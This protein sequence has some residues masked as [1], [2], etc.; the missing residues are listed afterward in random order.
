MRI[1]LRLPHTFQYLSH[2]SHSISCSILRNAVAASS[3]Y[4]SHYGKILF[5]NIITFS[6]HHQHL[7]ISLTLLKPIPY[8]DR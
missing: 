4:R 3:N 6:F 8:Y 7:Y 5:L 1:G 2:L